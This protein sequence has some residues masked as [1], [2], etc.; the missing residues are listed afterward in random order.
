MVLI[1]GKNP[2]QALNE[3]Y[4]G[5][6]Y[7]WE[8]PEGPVHSASFTVSVDVPI[9][10]DINQLFKETSTSKKDAK[11]KAAISALD[12]LKRTGIW[13]QRQQELMKNRV[14]RNAKNSKKQ[15][16]LLGKCEIYYI[17]Q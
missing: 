17:L 3:L 13:D 8:E 2:I 12:Y 11:L 15:V 10:P 6:Q 7:S 1:D 16:R 14:E 5:L 4:H 9:T